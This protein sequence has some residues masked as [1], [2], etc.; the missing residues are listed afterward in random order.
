MFR[1]INISAKCDKAKRHERGIRPAAAANFSPRMA[2][3]IDSTFSIRGKICGAIIIDTVDTLVSI[4][5]PSIIYAI[6]IIA[7]Q[8]PADYAGIIGA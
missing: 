3:T 6:I 1:L 8:V 5:A 2:G 7:M 4:I